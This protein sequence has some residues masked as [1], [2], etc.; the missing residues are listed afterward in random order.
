MRPVVVV[1]RTPFNLIKGGINGVKWVL[2]CTHFDYNT[3]VILRC[4]VEA[5]CV[6]N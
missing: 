3:V 2:I 4:F 6:Q 5:Y 1:V